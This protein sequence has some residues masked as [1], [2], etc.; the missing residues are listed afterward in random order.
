[1]FSGPNTDPSDIPTPPPGAFTWFVDLAGVPSIKRDDGSVVPS[2]TLLGGPVPLDEQGVVPT[3]V[4]NRGFVYSKD[5]GGI[6]ELFYE[7]EGGQEIQITDNGA[8]AGGG[9]GSGAFYDGSQKA[10]LTYD[11]IPDS[12]VTSQSTGLT[13]ALPAGVFCMVAIRAEHHAVDGDTGVH[14]DVTIVN[15]VFNDGVGTAQD[16]FFGGNAGELIGGQAIAFS[17]LGFTGNV[18]DLE[19]SNNSGSGTNRTRVAISFGPPVTL[20]FTPAPPPP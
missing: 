2:A 1:M 20:P 19:M 15:V 13:L 18:P 14:L 10:E 4:A 8:V 11:D 9:G 16:R 12:S 17:N 3:P 7:D 5:V 6:T